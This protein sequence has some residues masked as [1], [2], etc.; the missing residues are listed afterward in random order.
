VIPIPADF[1]FLVGKYHNGA[2]FKHHTW[3]APLQ[4]IVL[5]LLETAVSEDESIST[6]G[7]AALQILPGLVEH[8][9]HQRRKMLTPIELLRYIE[10]IL[11]K[12]VEIIRLAEP[13]F[14]TRM[15]S[16][17]PRRTYDMSPSGCRIQTVPPWVLR[18]TPCN[19]PVQTARRAL[20]QGSVHGLY[21]CL[22]LVHA[23]QRRWL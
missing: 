22:C 16:A 9:R 21:L 6:R 7:L 18:S 14:R 13:F 10:V 3:R 2:F 8:C 17:L 12:A 23:S 20:S 4:A 1:G 5:Q 19:S 11:D 15:S